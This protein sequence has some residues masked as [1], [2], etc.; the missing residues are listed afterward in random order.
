[1]A[2][3]PEQAARA[4]ETIAQKLQI[5]LREVQDNSFSMAAPALEFAIFALER[6]AER[7]ARRRGDA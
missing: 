4:A 5:L 1:M 2:S 3:S 6:D 7:I